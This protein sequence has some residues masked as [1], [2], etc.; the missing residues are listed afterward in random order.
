MRIADKMSLQQVQNN[1][2]KN[3]T[4]M[5]HLQE[6]SATQ[7]KVNRPSD[8]PLGSTRVL[9]AKTEERTQKQFIKS[10]QFASDFLKK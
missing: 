7:R 4:E 6:Q 5:H 10:L 2:S 1:L 3:R 9:N 8:D